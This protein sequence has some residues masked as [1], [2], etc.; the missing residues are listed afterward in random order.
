MVALVGGAHSQDIASP[1]IASEIVVQTLGA[2]QPA[3]SAVL[4]IHLQPGPLYCPG[5]VQAP[6]LQTHLHSDELHLYLEGG[7]KKAFGST[8]GGYFGAQIP[9]LHGSELHGL[10]SC[11]SFPGPLTLGHWQLHGWKNT[12]RKEDK[13][14]K[15]GFN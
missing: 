15:L 10:N 11:T 9:F 1:V 8:S 14:L 5:P 7:G 2:K 4:H 13:E 3:S 6:S 12:P